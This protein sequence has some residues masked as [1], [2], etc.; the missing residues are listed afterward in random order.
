MTTRK[1]AATEVADKEA[2]NFMSTGIIAGIV[3]AVIVIGVV[4][5]G[6]MAYCAAVGSSSA[7]ARNTTGW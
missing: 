2:A 5:F 6:L 4:V 1:G 7:S 3:A